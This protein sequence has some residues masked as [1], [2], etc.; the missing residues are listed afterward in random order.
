MPTLLRAVPVRAPFVDW[1]LEGKKTWEIRSR[2]TKIRG[3]I[4]L[5]K[6]RSLTVV[7][8]CEIVEVIGPLTRELIRQKAQAKMNEPPAE[9]FDC[10]GNYAW[11]LGNVRRFKKPVPYRHPSGAITWVKLDEATTAEVLAAR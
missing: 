9:C 11:V 5:I 4:G 8:R 6:S 10:V 1:I 3:V 2:S 7:G